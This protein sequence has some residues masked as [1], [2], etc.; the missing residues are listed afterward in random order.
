[1]AGEAKI[2]AKTFQPFG[3]L[4]A[5]FARVAELGEPISQHTTSDGIEVKIY[6][7]RFLGMG[8]SVKGEVKTRTDGTTF[9]VTTEKACGLVEF[10]GQQKPVKLVSSN[11]ELTEGQ[12][13]EFQVRSSKPDGD[14]K[15]MMTSTGSKVYWACVDTNLVATQK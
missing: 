10:D 2:E 3:L 9:A 1:M 11:V 5:P 8:K 7:G 15:Y 12:T 14:G 6:K 4:E 13:I